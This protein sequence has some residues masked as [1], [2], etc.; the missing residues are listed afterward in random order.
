MIDIQ[1]KNEVS[2][3]AQNNTT[4]TEDKP[5]FQMNKVNEVLPETKMNDDAN[6]LVP[7]IKK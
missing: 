5:D 4:E 6:L 2:K 7:D 3:N 1:C